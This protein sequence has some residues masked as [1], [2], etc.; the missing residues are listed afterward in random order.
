ML[1]T[2]GK[3]SGKENNSPWSPTLHGTVTTVLIWK[4]ILLQYKPRISHYSQ[5]EYQTKSL[6][7]PIDIQWITLGDIKRN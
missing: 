7:T 3:I 5:K 2:E 6:K 4:H 1:K